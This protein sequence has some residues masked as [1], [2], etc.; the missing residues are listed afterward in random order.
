MVPIYDS[1]AVIGVGKLVR[2]DSKSLPFP[3]PDEGDPDY[4]DFCV[5]FW[6]LYDACRQA[7]LEVTV[8]TLDHCLWAVPTSV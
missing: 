5:R 4:Y 6:R 7:G 2:W 1:Y 8:K 3:R